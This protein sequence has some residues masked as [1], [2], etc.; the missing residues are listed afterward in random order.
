MHLMARF[1]EVIAEDLGT[2]P[3]YLRPSLE[4]S[5]IAGY[6]VL[7][8]EKDEDKYR[9]PGEWPEISAAAN[10]THD[11]DTTAAWWDSLSPDDRKQ[12]QTIPAL[13]SIDPNAPFG[14][15][16]RDA[17]L[18][19]LYGSRSTLTLVPLE[20]LLGGKA[21]VN[22]PSASEG[23]W[24]YR[25]RQTVDDLSKDGDTTKRLADLAAETGRTPA[26]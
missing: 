19:A 24:T 13:A 25:V 21:R 7:R 9:D 14:P 10:S 16:I 22:D 8:W 17:I 5:G 6:R 12:L 3:G 20:D 18:R 1:G 26:R 15:P 4:R 11:T 2:V 23:N